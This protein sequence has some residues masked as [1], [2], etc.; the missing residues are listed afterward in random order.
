MNPSKVDRQHLQCLTDLPNIGKEMAKDLVLL[1]YTKPEDIVG[2][3][4]FDM[5]KRLCDIT[6]VRQDPCVIDVFLS[7]IDFLDGNPPRSW[8][9]YTK[10]R[11]ELL[12]AG[13]KYKE[14]K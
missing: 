11:K 14:R 2:E 10:Q 3:C 7:V 4:A 8:W 9:E 1:G 13:H 12:A 6:G 5:H